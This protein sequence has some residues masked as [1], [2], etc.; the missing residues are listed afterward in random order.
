MD[1]LILQRF[2]AK[3]D[4]RSDDECWPWTG[5]ILSNGYGQFGVVKPIREYAH[6]F[7][8]L[9]ER[10]PISPGLVLDHLCRNRACVNPR[11]L[12]AVTTRVNILRGEAPSARNAKAEKC[13]YGHPFTPENTWAQNKGMGRKCKTCHRRINKRQA[14]RGEVVI[15]L[16]P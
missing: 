1:A 11:H 4:R 9:L 6:R 8:Y 12:E 15:S 3:V 7:S 10:G 5:C 14:Q 13:I 2:W 16:A